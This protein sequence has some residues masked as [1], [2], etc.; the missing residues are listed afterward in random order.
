[1]ANMGLAYSIASASTDVNS[2]IEHEV[3]QAFGF[4]EDGGNGQKVSS[5]QMSAVFVRKDDSGQQPVPEH[6][7]LSVVAQGR[8]L[9]HD[10]FYAAQVHGVFVGGSADEVCGVNVSDGVFVYVARHRGS[11]SC[12]LE[13]EGGVYLAVH[14]NSEFLVFPCVGQTHVDLCQLGRT[15]RLLAYGACQSGAQ[16]IHGALDGGRRLIRI[17]ALSE[18]ALRQLRDHEL[19]PF[20][21]V[22]RL[23]AE[24]RKPAY[25]FSGRRMDVV[26]PQREH[27]QR[28]ALCERGV[29]LPF[30]ARRAELSVFLASLLFNPRRD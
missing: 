23:P 18:R 19:H 17:K 4:F 25:D 28:G 24:R 27:F 8:R 30:D 12:G 26:F 16:R 5:L 13:Q 20:A 9:E 2:Q 15:A 3:K 1:M 10:V 7:L 11:G 22:V 14:E 6:F 29:H 21:P